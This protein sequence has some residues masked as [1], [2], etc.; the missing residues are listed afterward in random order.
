MKLQACISQDDAALAYL[1][2]GTGAEIRFAGRLGKVHDAKVDDRM[3]TPTDKIPPS[4]SQL[5][6]GDIQTD[7]SDP[8]GEKTTVPQIEVWLKLSDA[9][10]QYVAGQRAYVHFKLDRKPLIWNWTRRVWQVIQ[11]H[12]HGKWT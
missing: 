5:A 10:D 1:K 7:P 2:K 3:A 9:K 11:S 6:G 8:K 12:S 4:L